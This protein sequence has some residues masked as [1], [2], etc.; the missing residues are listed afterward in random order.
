MFSAV[1]KNNKKP[2]NISCYSGKSPARVG[3]TDTDSKS[4]LWP[5]ADHCDHHC[6]H[7]L[8][9]QLKRSVWTKKVCRISFHRSKRL[10]ELPDWH[11]CGHFHSCFEN[12][13]SGNDRPKVYCSVVSNLCKNFSPF[14]ANTYLKA[15]QPCSSRSEEENMCLGFTPRVSFAD[16][17]EVGKK[18][19]CTGNCFHDL[20]GHSLPARLG[21]NGLTLHHNKPF[22]NKPADWTNQPSKSCQYLTVLLINWIL[23]KI[24]LLGFALTAASCMQYKWNH[25]SASL[26]WT[27][28]MAKKAEDQTLTLIK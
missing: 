18:S 28:L 6:D 8:W 4:S 10:W 21:L 25:P 27:V 7:Q 9:L 23:N 2:L 3:G 22:A 1:E 14:K 15:H 16:S 11:Q 20:T 5:S 13:M 24:R 12:Q 19:W 17:W 26:A